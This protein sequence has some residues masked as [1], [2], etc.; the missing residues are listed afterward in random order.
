MT[1]AVATATAA[2]GV[3]AQQQPGQA[4][5]LGLLVLVLLGIA[6]FLLVRNMDRRLKRLPKEFPPRE[7]DQ[8][9]GRGGPEPR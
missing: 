1:Y 2:S 7:D 5:P 4:G 8:P 3:L 9:D 6:V